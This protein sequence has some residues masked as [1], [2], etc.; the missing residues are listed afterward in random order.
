MHKIEKRYL[1]VLQHHSF[2]GQVHTLY[3]RAL[4]EYAPRKGEILNISCLQGCVEYVAHAVVNEGLA[5]DF[6][7]KEPLNVVPSS[8]VMETT[9]RL[10]FGY[11]HSFTIEEIFDAMPEASYLTEITGFDVSGNSWNSLT[12]WRK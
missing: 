10:E 12:G 8:F 11:N 3:W 1:K 4:S 2:C 9:V 6:G 5:V 7:D